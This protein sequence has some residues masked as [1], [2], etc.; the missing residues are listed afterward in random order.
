MAR[1]EHPPIVYVEWV[2]AAL[3]TAKWEQRDEL[4]AEASRTATPITAAGFLLA[5]DP[6]GIIVCSLY[7]WHNDDASGAMLI[8]RAQI[9][10]LVVLRAAR[11]FVHEAA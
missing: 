10:K 6:R 1:P 2:D 5:D 3:L 8:P 7:N 9:T 11:G 4:L